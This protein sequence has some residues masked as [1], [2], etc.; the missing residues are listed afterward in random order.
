MF[1]NNNKYNNRAFWGTVIGTSIGI[2]VS[3]QISPLNKR[4]M[5]RTA[6]KV[7]SNFKDGVNNLWS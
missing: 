3:S 1:N 7:K 6:R 4:K 5:M 2:I